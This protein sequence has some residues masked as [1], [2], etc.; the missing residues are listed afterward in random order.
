MKNTLILLIS[1]TIPLLALG[2]DPKELVSLRETWTRDR[3]QVTAPVDR[4]YLDALNT[5][6]LRFTRAGQLE[7]ALAVDSELKAVVAVSAPATKQTSEKPVETRKGLAEV[8]QSSKW[9]TED[10]TLKFISPSEFQYQNEP[11]KP[12]KIVSSNT[13]ELHWNGDSAKATTCVIAKD[14]MSFI[15][16]GNQTWRRKP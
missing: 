9:T 12:F 11:P 1:V 10:K 7:A 15:E 4:K 14:G 3:I 16:H 2:E 5:L 6:K 13:F 8:L